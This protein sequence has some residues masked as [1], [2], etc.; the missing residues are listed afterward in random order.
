MSKPIK[1]TDGNFN[2]EVLSADKKVLVDFWAEWC[3]P[4]R[5][6]APV[7]E[8]IAAEYGDKIKVAKLNVDENQS[9]ASRYGI[10]SIPTMLVMEDGKVIN[11][12]VGYMP[13]D[14]L[15]SKLNLK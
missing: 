5:M 7:V 2:T 12:L 9:T 6:V 4:C 8:D 3:G 1:V 13:K 15:V 11:K 10:M 14:K